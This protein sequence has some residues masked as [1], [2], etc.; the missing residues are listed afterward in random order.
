MATTIIPK[1]KQLRLVRKGRIEAEALVWLSQRKYF[2]P[3]SKILRSWS[4]RTLHR[5][6][7]P[8]SGARAA[9]CAAA[10]VCFQCPEL[11]SVLAE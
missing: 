2:V 6:L 5:I 3:K 7:I 1:P 10:K 11:L 8:D 9:R 4:S